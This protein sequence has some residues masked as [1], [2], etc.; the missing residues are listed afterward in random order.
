MAKKSQKVIKFRKP[1]KI[2]VELIIVL[3]ILLYIVFSVYASFKDSSM[4]YYE[5]VKGKIVK[6]ESFTGI[7][8]R[9]EKTVNAN[10]NG[11]IHYVIQEGRR[12]SAGAQI[13]TLD[14]TGE[15]EAYLREHPELIGQMSK[16]QIE[17]IRYDLSQFSKQFSN[18]RYHLLYDT[19]YSLDA[20]IL[21]YS[22]MSDAVNLNEILDAQSIR[23]SVVRSGEAGVVSYSIDGMEGF[24]EADISQERFITAGYKKNII[25]PGSNLQEGQ[26]AYKLITS[27]EWNLVFPA[28][29]KTVE[30]FRDTTTVRI[31]FTSL[32]IYTMAGLSFFTGKDG[33]SYGELRLNEFMEQF[34]GERY[35]P[36]EIITSDREGLKIPLTAL[37]EKEFF[38]VPRDFCME[39]D[40]N[41]GFERTVMS[42][43]GKGTTTE[44]VRAE[45]YREDEQFYYLNIPESA[46]TDQLRMNDY[47]V[48]P[49]TD[50]NYRIGPAKSLSGVYNINKGYCVFRQI[51]PIEKNN[52]YMIVRTGT[53]YGIAV[54]DHIVLDS[55]MA[56]EGMLIYR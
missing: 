42:A 2:N 23:Y 54:Y 52:E 40:G 20:R 32:D 6:D 16:E 38:V 47:I 34:C 30:I 12:V 39:Q 29:E 19:K 28:D 25:K 41:K 51:V 1:F 37:T 13:Y 33:R 35:I 15:L 24:T 26:P 9:Q 11:H 17:E 56:Y 50:D 55:S 22:N 48:R 7:A 44:F 53:D 8:L 4:R 31:H 3:I 18:D 49:G 5:V 10:A 14:E 45:I 27:S 21:E 46:E 43:D 36:F